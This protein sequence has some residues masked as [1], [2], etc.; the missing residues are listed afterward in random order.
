MIKHSASAPTRRE[1]VLLAFLFISLLWISRANFSVR[2]SRPSSLLEEEFIE[3]HDVSQDDV[4]S[5]EAERWRTRVS[6]KR[7]PT[8][9]IVSHVPGWTIFDN[10][11]LLNGTV[12]IVS[13]E[14]KQ[15]PDRKTIIST[16]V[17]IDNGDVA[18]ASRLPTDRE[19]RVISTDD[20]RELFGTS[21][22]LIDGATWIVNDP[23]QF[24][25]HY[26]H[27]SAELFFGFWRTYSSLDPFIPANGS[28]SLPA[29]RRVWFAHA[30]ADHWRDYA[31]MN[32]W[33]LRSAF[34]S[35]SAEYS[36]D[37]Q[38]RA[39]MGRP[40]MLD[41]VIFSD[42]AAAM[43]GAEFLRTGRIASE[44]FDLPGS[45]HWW[46]TIRSEVIKFSGLDGQIG[47]GTTHNPVITYISRQEWGR[48]MLIPE[49]HEKLVG[50]LYNLRDKYG[51]EVNV[52]SMDKLSRVEQFQLA[53][54]TTIM[55][56]VHGNGLTSLVWMKP[57]PRATV[58]EFFY[59]GGFAHD[60]EYTTRALGMVHYGVWG[61][62]T[63]THPDT[64][65]AA[66]PEGFQGNSIP[67]NGEVVARLCLER[68]GLS[69]TADD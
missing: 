45:V 68:F 58:I 33:V 5:T 12:F 67:V 24:I 54:R 55:M 17:K 57:S 15:V 2:E 32:Q 65:P 26:Y 63:F 3:E 13:D 35:L 37:W 40:V 22:A 41:R 27:W 4:P 39:E 50:E 28:S 20:A 47:A 48:R 30:D 66:Y 9:R 44:A 16:A 69:N 46:N 56:G 29:P 19:L 7:I 49:D 61:D 31:L 25:T 60:Y 62:K 14:P 1:F 53:A 38:D 64:P 6:S 34:P 8:T 42:R 11:Y 52:V 59:P 43:N 10:L 51:Y 36:A 18:V 23:P 21:P